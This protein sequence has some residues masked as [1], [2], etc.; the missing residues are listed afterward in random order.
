MFYIAPNFQPFLYLHIR[1]RS[2]AQHCVLPGSYF[3]IS[4]IATYFHVTK[5]LKILNLI[6]VYTNHKTAK[7]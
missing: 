2:M 1:C 5:T 3:T 4:K 6:N 7:C